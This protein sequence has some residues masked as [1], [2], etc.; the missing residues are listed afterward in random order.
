MFLFVNQRASSV[1]APSVT[2]LIVARH[3]GRDDMID[4]TESSER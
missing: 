3:D 1:L 2:H 4:M